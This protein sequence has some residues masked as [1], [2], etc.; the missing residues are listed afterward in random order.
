LTKELK[1]TIITLMNVFRV[2]TAG[3]DPAV[4]PEEVIDQVGRDALEYRLAQK[5]RFDPN[6]A[7]MDADELDAGRVVTLT[8]EAR[9]HNREIARMVAAGLCRKFLTASRD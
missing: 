5:F 2:E 8:P 6:K 4:R 7:V 9:E 3:I 1:F